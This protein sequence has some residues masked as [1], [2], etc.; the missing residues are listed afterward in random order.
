MS[1]NA[2]VKTGQG[3]V[4]VY[5]YKF[6]NKLKRWVGHCAPNKLKIM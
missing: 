1:E 2:D 6:V 4:I 5:F 3:G